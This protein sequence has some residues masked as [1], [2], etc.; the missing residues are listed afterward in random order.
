MNVA[1]TKELEAIVE[2]RVKTGRW[3]NRSDFI[4]DCI[5]HY[6]IDEPDFDPTKD[7]PELAELLRQSKN[8]PAKPHKKGDLK[9][10]LEKVRRNVGM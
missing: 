3:Q 1:L 9:R 2:A 8:S 4:R 7:T 10:L 6:I 5:R